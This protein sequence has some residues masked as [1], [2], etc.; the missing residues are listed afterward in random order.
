MKRNSVSSWQYSIALLCLCLLSGSRHTL[1]TDV[2]SGFHQYWNLFFLFL[3]CGKIYI[4]L[5]WWLSGKESPCQC[6]MRRFNSWVG[7]IP[8]RRKWQPTPVILAWKI[9]WTEEPDG[10]QFMGLTKQLSIHI[11]DRQ[12]CTYTDTHI[13]FKESNTD[14]TDILKRSLWLQHSK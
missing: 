1:M 11:Y 14:W 12:I 2:G 10:L 4:G 6:R 7:K 3:N 8:W 9:P 5:P 13:W